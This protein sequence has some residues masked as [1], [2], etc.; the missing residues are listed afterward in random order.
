MGV[1]QQAANIYDLI[2]TFERLIFLLKLVFQGFCPA[3][4]SNK[5]VNDVTLILVALLIFFFFNHANSDLYIKKENETNMYT[6]ST[7]LLN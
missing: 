5:K 6:K 2:Q 7:E 3:E 4:D 1:Q